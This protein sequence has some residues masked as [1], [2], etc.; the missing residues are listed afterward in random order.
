MSKINL[1]DFSNV[2]IPKKTVRMLGIMVLVILILAALSR[3]LGGSET[4]A[5]YAEKHPEQQITV[6][7]E[8]VDGK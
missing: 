8:T 4:L 3:T 2:K 1:P 7:T 5:D 6:E